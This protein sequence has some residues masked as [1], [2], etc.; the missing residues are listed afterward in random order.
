[1][2]QDTRSCVSGQERHKMH[3]V[4]FT[5][6]WKVPDFN[7][8]YLWNYSTDFYQ[9]YIFYALHINDLT[10]K[11]RV[12]GKQD[13][14]FKRLPN[15]LHIFLLLILLTAFEEFLNHIKTSFPWFNF[16]QIWHIY[17]TH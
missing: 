9:I 4:L 16:F 8:L 17:M 15:F 1:M 12:S 14:H 11:N 13:I 10:Y 2:H 7:P 3:S 6:K 5:R